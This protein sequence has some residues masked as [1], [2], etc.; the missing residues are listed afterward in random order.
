MKSI[1]LATLEDLDALMS[2]F[3]SVKL[4]LSRIGLDQWP[5]YYPPQPVVRA[6]LSRSEVFVM[7]ADALLIGT[8]TLNQV[9]DPAYKQIKWAIAADAPYVVHRLVVHPDYWGQGLGRQWMRF[10]EAQAQERGGQAIRL[11]TY[12]KNIASNALYTNL[13]Y[14]LA[15]GE[16]FF[17]GPE[18]SF[19]C[20]EKAL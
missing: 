4:G 3:S 6:D 2:L 11:D 17:Y 18:K 12:A 7:E 10:A 14:Q 20:F 5:D 1:R 9:Q 16:C 13:G 19:I 15:E 8:L